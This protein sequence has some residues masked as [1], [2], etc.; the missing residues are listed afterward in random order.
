MLAVIHAAFA[1]YADRVDPPSGALSETEA[2]LQETLILANAFVAQSPRGTAADIAGCVFYTLE[3]DH[4]YLFRLAVEPSQRRQSIGRALVERVEDEAR[5]RGFDRVQLSVRTA[6]LANRFTYEAMGYR[7]ID[8]R[9]HPGFDVYTYFV[10]E[11]PL[12]SS[13]STAPPAPLDRAMRNIHVVPYDPAW[14]EM[15]AAEAD[16]LRH[17]L[18]DE[19]VAIHHMGST[20]I[21]GCP[22]KPII[23]I[24]PVVRDIDR[25]DRRN[26][27]LVALDYDPRGENGIPGRRYF[28]KGGTTQR[29]HHVHVFQAGH[30]EIR[31]H[32]DFCAYLAAHPEAMGRYVARKQELARR[33]PH[34]ILAYNRGKSDL[35]RTLDQ[36]A[37][38]WRQAGDEDVPP[39]SG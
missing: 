32:L 38:R 12:A 14:A 39:V 29:S 17:A 25:V 8:R 5:R 33:F 4:V 22:A 19:L 37:A 2:G 3:E 21:V 9:C 16:R 23:A 13:S 7:I 36:A 20:A 30:P 6:L 28:S 24:L 18:G 11:K 27:W 10:M 15:Y 1:Q 26:P 34:D 35:I 31:R